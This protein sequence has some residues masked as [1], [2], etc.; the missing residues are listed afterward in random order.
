MTSA[1]AVAVGTTRGCARSTGTQENMTAA[2]QRRQQYSIPE[3]LQ[4]PLPAWC[5]TSRSRGCE[6]GDF[7]PWQRNL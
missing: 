7:A 5:A 6:D 4:D 1:S 2:T 3:A